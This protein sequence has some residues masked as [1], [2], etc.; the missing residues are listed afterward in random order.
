MPNILVLTAH[1]DVL[2][3]HDVLI[4]DQVKAICQNA[5]GLFVGGAKGGDSIALASACDLIESGKH[6][7]VTIVVPATA[8]QQPAE[9]RGVIGRAVSLGA[10]IVEL[11]LPYTALALKERNRQMVDLAWEAGTVTLLAYWRGIY[12]SGTYSCIKY[13]WGSGPA[14]AERNVKYI[15]F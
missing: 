6:L 5:D 14:S 9:A 12:K 10:K 7:P 8:T 3:G 15:K 4:A 2:P 13:Y 11:G 1:R